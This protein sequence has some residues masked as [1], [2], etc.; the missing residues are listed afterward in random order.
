MMRNSPDPE[1][2]EPETDEAEEVFSEEAVR[3]FHDP[4]W[5][6]GEAPPPVTTVGTGFDRPAAPDVEHDHLFSHRKPKR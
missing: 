5:L 3:P 1:F 4:D 6:D 2:D